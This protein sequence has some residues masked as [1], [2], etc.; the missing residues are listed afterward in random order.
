VRP[1]H[2]L[3]AR[4]DLD[5]RG[6]EA[7]RDRRAHVRIEAAQDVCVAVDQYDARAQPR[8]DVR[9]LPAD[10]AAAAAVGASALGLGT[11]VAAAAT[12]AAA[13]V[14]GF[15]AA[16]VLA[17]LGF[18]ILPA[19]RKR[20]KEEM[21]AKIADL[22]ERLSTALREQFTRE[23][24]RSVDRIR[25]SVAPYSRFVRAEGD[26]LNAVDHELQEV[27]A[28]LASLRARIERVA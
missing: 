6:G 24:G 10:V 7:L 4:R 19:K 17:A 21:R 26:K 27:T 1:D 11:I 8:E 18:F 3:R 20:A 12:T 22:R 14:T 25:E 23:I 16:S 13:D 28:A 15:I 9:E 5:A 2:E